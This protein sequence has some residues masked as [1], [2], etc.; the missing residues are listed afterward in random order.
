MIFLKVVT[1][2]VEEY[3]GQTLTGKETCAKIKK[4]LKI[5]ISYISDKIKYFKVH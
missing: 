1:S 4:N 3:L 2:V 5:I